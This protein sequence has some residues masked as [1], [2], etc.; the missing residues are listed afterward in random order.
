MY[1]YLHRNIFS[2]FLEHAIGVGLLD[3]NSLYNFLSNYQGVFQNS[4]SYSL[5]TYIFSH[6]GPCQ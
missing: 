6:S 5:P 4:E 2:S 1:K 3:L